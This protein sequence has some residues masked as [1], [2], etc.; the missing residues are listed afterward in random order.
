MHRI[1]FTIDDCNGLTPHLVCDDHAPEEC[2]YQEVFQ[3]DTSSA[4]EGYYG[5]RITFPDIPIEV[6]TASEDEGFE[7]QTATAPHVTEAMEDAVMRV[8]PSNISRS[9]ARRAIIAALTVH[10]DRSL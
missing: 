3:R 1:R 4:M 2:G 6:I 5:D 8:I 10:T 9:E 7:W